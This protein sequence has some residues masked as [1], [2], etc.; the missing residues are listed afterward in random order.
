MTK[1]KDKIDE[2]ISEFKEEANAEIVEGTSY[3]IQVVSELSIHANAEALTWNTDGTLNTYAV[4][5]N[6]NTYTLT[7]GWNADGTLASVTPVVT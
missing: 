5:V 6:G 1:K 4:T 2:A 3:G 7:L